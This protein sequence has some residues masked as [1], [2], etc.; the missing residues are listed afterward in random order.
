MVYEALQFQRQ[1][2][3]AASQSASLSSAGGSNPMLSYFFERADELGKL[4]SVL[5]LS[6][7][8][9]SEVWACLISVLIHVLIAS[10]ASS[11]FFYVVQ[12]FKKKKKIPG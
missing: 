1:R 7:T 9:V 8:Q 3:G 2:S 10:P 11:K 6:L 12:S 4:D 5:Q